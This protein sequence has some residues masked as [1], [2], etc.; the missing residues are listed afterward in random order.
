MG[1][2]RA[3][4]WGASLVGMVCVVLGVWALRLARDPARSAEPW[5]A[6][7][8]S[9]SSWAGGWSATGHPHPDFTAFPRNEAE[10]V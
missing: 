4:L 3:A 7:D 9:W 2:R 6:W 1:K 8:A 10:G 5:P